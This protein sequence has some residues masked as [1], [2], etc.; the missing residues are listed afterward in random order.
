[1]ECP[2]V[3]AAI[4]NAVKA[5]PTFN[6]VNDELCPDAK[7]EDRNYSEVLAH[8]DEMKIQ[9]EKRKLYPKDCEDC[10]NFLKTNFDMRK[11]IE[12]C[13]IAKFCN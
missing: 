10:G 2:T 4:E 6:E 5:G 8:T 12:A 9:K 1:M 11:H 7:Y 13:M 3:E